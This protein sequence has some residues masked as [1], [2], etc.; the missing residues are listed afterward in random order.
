MFK[1]ER[2]VAA[3]C[4]LRELDD[5]EKAF[6]EAEEKEIENKRQKEKREQYE[7]LKKEFEAQN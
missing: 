2:I 3:V 4:G 6:K 7:K 1:K 5:L